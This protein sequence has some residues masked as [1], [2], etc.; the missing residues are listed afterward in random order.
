MLGL[1]VRHHMRRNEAFFILCILGNRILFGLLL[2]VF[3]LFG[4]RFGVLGVIGYALRLYKVRFNP[5]PT[6]ATLDKM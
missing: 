6:P 2:V 3:L 5:S 4:V 1:L